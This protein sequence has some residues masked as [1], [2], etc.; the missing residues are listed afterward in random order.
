MRMSYKILHFLNCSTAQMGF[1]KILLC[2]PTAPYT[3]AHELQNRAPS[4][5]WHYT[6]SNNSWT[7]SLR[8]SSNAPLRLSLSSCPSCRMDNDTGSLS[9][10]AERCDSGVQKKSWT[11]P[12]ICCM[13]SISLQGLQFFCSS[14]TCYSCDL[15]VSMSLVEDSGNKMQTDAVYLFTCNELSTSFSN[16]LHDCISSI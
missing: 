12:G 9:A 2:Y 5:Q 8:V 14:C 11:W 6:N 10:R 7:L 3:P 13:C 16:W 4:Q 1:K 15:M